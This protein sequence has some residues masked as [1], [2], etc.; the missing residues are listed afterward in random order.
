MLMATEM[1]T[2]I[3]KIVPYLQRRGYSL[4]N[5]MFFGERAENE[6]ERVGFVDILV[7][8]SPR[9]TR[10][11]FVIEAKRDSAKLNASHRK[12]AISYGRVLNCSFVVVT[13]GEDFELLNTATGKRLK[14]NGSIIGKVPPYSRIDAVLRQLRDNRFLDNIDSLVKTRFEEVPAL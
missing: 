7:K 2:V 3:K 13:N 5:N 10:P 6:Q 14:V 1:T 8:R 11:L 12:Q 9:A 4:D